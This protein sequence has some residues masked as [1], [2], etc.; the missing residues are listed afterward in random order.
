MRIIDDYSKS[1]EQKSKDNELL[2]NKI[3]KKNLKIEDLKKIKADQEVKIGKLRSSLDNVK[4][5]LKLLSQNFI[6][7][8]K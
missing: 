4:T 8:V 1:I 2:T 5:F 7:G 6:K 3:D